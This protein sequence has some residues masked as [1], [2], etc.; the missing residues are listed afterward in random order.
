MNA[1]HREACTNDVAAGPHRFNGSSEP[2]ELFPWWARRVVVNRRRWG[3]DADRLASDR[4]QRMN[5]FRGRSVALFGVA[6][7]AALELIFLRNLVQRV[8][9]QRAL[10]YEDVDDE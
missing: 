10:R 5:Q 4:A 3:G 6:I 7:A 1:K 9:G 8:T 2:N